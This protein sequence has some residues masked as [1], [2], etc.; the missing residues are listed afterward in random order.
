[1]IFAIPPPEYTSR[2]LHSGPGSGSLS[3]AAEA[4]ASLGAQLDD[5][6]TTYRAATSALGSGRSSVA[7]LVGGMRPYVAW[8]DATA[9]RVRHT[10]V[11]A[12][13]A[14]RAYGSTMALVPAPQVVDANRLRR[15]TLAATNHLGRSGP[16]IADADA[17]YEN[18]WA[19]GA[20]AMHAYARASAAAAT[21]LPFAAPPPVDGLREP[22][23]RGARVTR[24]RAWRLTVAPETIETGCAVIAAIP[25]ALG[26]LA[27]APP[28]AF[29]ASLMSV[30][31]P[32]SKLSSLS[33]PSDVALSHLNLLNKAA[34]LHRAATLRFP[35]VGCPDH[36]VL[37]ASVGAAAS[38]GALSVPEAWPRSL[39]PPA[40]H[41]STAGPLDRSQ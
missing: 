6:A 5:L 30:T 28:T 12:R 37:K 7:R 15:I 20:A 23:H 18:M 13:A 17:E 9:A 22:V 34:A 41:G 19:R 2:Q 27:A 32:L 10:A 39:P 4:W 33:A 21:L 31:A 26:A 8:L 36:A 24:S 1:M 3:E 38:V 25:E 16:A 29:D 11:Q 35:D 14:A 40:W